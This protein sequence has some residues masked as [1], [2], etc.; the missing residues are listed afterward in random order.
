MRATGL[1]RKKDMSVDTMTDYSHN[2]GSFL[3]RIF[4]AVV[5]G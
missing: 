2:M 3:G 4:E 1:D 5:D